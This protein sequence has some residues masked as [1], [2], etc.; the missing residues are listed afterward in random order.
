MVYRTWLAE[1]ADVNRDWLAVE[2][3]YFLGATLPHRG[4]TRRLQTTWIA[5]ALGETPVPEDMAINM[6][7]DGM[8]A[9]DAELDEWIGGD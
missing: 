4:V 6:V 1:S 2:Y 5:A 8:I 7:I 3:Q 9:G